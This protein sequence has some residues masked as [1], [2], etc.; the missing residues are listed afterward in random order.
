VVTNSICF[1]VKER[2]VDRCKT[3][4][5]IA[6]PSRRS[7][8]PSIVRM[9]LHQCTISRKLMMP[10]A[11][12]HPTPFAKD[13]GASAS[14]LRLPRRG[15]PTSPSAVAHC[16]LRPPFLIK[17]DPG[18]APPAFSCGTDL[19]ATRTVAAREFCFVLLPDAIRGVGL[20]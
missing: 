19:V 11:H 9:L 1:S 12:R 10:N 16:L 8:T 20:R 4:T 5:P 6:V 2:T 3:I 15:S 13:Y 14:A 7:G 18:D 17:L